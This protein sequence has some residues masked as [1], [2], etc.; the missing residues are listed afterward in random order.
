MNWVRTREAAELSGANVHLFPE[1]EREFP[2]QFSRKVEGKN[3]FGPDGG[4]E[5][6]PAFIQRMRFLGRFGFKGI[7]AARIAA[8]SEL[9]PLGLL[10]RTPQK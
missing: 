5:W 8:V 4:V 6:C 9:T 3:L 7:P 10:I 1:I 2:R